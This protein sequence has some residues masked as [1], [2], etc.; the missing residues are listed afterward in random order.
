MKNK[1]IKIAVS[2]IIATSAFVAVSPSKKGDAASNMEQL[3]VDAQNA[4]NVLKWAISVEGSADGVTQPWEQFNDA[5]MAIAKV[6]AGLSGVNF[7]D[8]LKYEARLVDPK[9]QI[10]R[11]QGYLDAITASS[12]IHAKTNSLSA[13]VYSNN[14]DQVE[15]AYH[16]MT[17]EFRKQ[18][19]LLDRVY[20]QSTRDRIRNAVK[21][22]AE[23]LIN[24]LKND[25]T[26][27][28][29]AKGAEEDVRRGNYTEA[30]KKVYEAQAI[31][32]SNVL[33]WGKALQFRIENVNT[34][35]PF[36]IVSSSIVNNTT[37]TIKL[38][39]PVSSI[40][41]SDFSINNG[42]TVTNATLSKDGLTITLT[43]SI[44]IP[45]TT[46]TLKYKTNT[47][48]FTIPGNVIPIYV[49]DRTVQ[50]RETS[51]VITL[52]AIFKESNGKPSTATVRVDIPVGLKLVSVN[53]AANNTA[54]ANSVNVTPD[55]N[56]MVTIV[57]TAKDLTSPALDKLITFNKMEKNKVVETQTSS[58]FNFYVPA[59]AGL[60]SNKNV[61]F[62]D[63][64]FGYFVTTDGIKYKLKGYG[65][66]YQIDGTPI[67]FDSFKA[68]LNIGNIING[69]YHPTSTSSFNI[70]YNMNI[71]SINLNSKFTY[72]PGTMGY[73]MNGSKIELFG[74]GQPNYDLFFFKNAGVSLGKTKVN[75]NGTWTFTTN[76]DANTLTDYSIVQQIAGISMP[77]YNSGNAI[78][79][80]VIE[81]PF[82]IAWISDGMSKDENLSNE[83][84][85]FTIAPLK[86]NNG[87]IL[88]QD[89]AIIS[90]QASIVLKDSDGTKVKFTN[91]QNDTYF[92][93]VKNGFNIRF[94][95][96]I[97]LN[98]GKDG[99][100]S[101]ALSIE[102]V[103]GVTNEYGLTLKINTADQINRY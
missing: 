1:V 70:F 6:E 2:S 75:T 94:G 77:P 73:R 64:N 65:D 31:L 90:K 33:I 76:V 20:G 39:K 93:T 50:H 28:M 67:S 54:G 30:A 103:E 18:T 102:S 13:A 85:T 88:T 24:E 42:L 41:T 97:M 8:K 101:G 80:R 59:N 40:K 82:E 10:Q 25:V 26:V 3:M 91:S 45:G 47:F 21:G 100:L 4:S 79:L 49:G 17:A 56:G 63:S 74:T 35:L 83:E 9:V 61:R 89:Q 34:S 84:I 96:G 86:Y 37:L 71:S 68:T 57:F 19:I 38:N 14:L 51:E 99:K 7:S 78:T 58:S 81:G 11:A 60:F 62:I 32:R 22:P 53:G 12:K 66:V 69:T 27:H 43:T 5:K 29:L 52:A 92:T 16:E 55:K 23:K 98:K 87:S 44:Q 15:K 46:Y 95:S 48:S 72:K 36:Q